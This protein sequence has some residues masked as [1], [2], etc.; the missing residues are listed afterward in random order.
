MLPGPEPK[1]AEDAGQ[2]EQIGDVR[3]EMRARNVLETS[4]ALSTRAPAV[5]SVTPRRSRRRGRPCRAEPV[6]VGGQVDHLSA[7]ASS[8]VDE[9]LRPRAAH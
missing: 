1:N 3:P 2:Q 8:A 6:E 9:M 7:N 4:G 5:C